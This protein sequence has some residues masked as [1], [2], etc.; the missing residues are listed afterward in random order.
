LLAITGHAADE[1]FHLR[2]DHIFIFISY[3]DIAWYLMQFII[4]FFFVALVIDKSNNKKMT[5]ATGAGV[6][7]TLIMLAYL[8][9]NFVLNQMP[10]EVVF[11][12]VGDMYMLEALNILRLVLGIVLTIVGVAIAYASFARKNNMMIPVIVVCAAEF[13]KLILILGRTG[14]MLHAVLEIV[15]YSGF[16]LMMF[17]YA[18]NI[19]KAQA[20]GTLPVA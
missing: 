2:G 13:I 1:F 20:D 8:P 4:L 14:L 9:M 12:P 18:R 6:L 17:T 16:A 5:L 10:A 15:L 7:G 3:I 11:K 19:D